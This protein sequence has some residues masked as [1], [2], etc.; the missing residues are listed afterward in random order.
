MNSWPGKSGGQMPPVPPLATPLTWNQPRLDLI[1]VKSLRIQ[2]QEI[3]LQSKWSAQ[4]THVSSIFDPSPESFRTCNPH[5][6]EQLR[7]SLLALNKPCAFLHISVPYIKK[8][9]HDHSYS[10]YLYP[11]ESLSPVKIRSEPNS[12]PTYTARALDVDTII[13]FKDSLQVSSADGCRTETDTRQQFSS[14]EW[15]SVWAHRI[16][17]SICDQIPIQH[18]KMFPLYLQSL[19]PKPMFD[20]LPA[21]MAWGRQKELVACRK[22]R[23]TWS[24]MATKVSQHI[25]VVLSSIQLRAGLEHHQMHKLSILHAILFESQN[26]SAPTWNETSHH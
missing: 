21:A 14:K 10:R 16:T 2:K 17:S 18:K 3:A 6:S 7:C 5:A 12:T 9:W 1:P 15:F 8:V 19:Y 25:L 24:N 26:L 22:Y 11:V 23:S 20:P 13:T 4:L